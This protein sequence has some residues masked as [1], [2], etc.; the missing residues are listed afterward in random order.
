MEY[1]LIS[2]EHL[3][4]SLLF[5]DFDDFVVG[6]NYVAVQAYKARINMLAF[7]L[8][9]NHVHFVAEGDRIQVETFINGFKGE[10][11]RYLWNKYSI[12]ELLRRKS[13]DIRPIPK[14][15]ES[16][17]RAIAYVQMNCV[18]ANICAHPVEYPWG[19]G[20]TFFSAS[21]ENG[22]CLRDLSARERIRLLHT[23][24]ELPQ[25]WSVCSDGYVTP[26]SYVCKDFVERIFRTPKRMNFFL[27]NSSKAKQRVETGEKNMPAFRDQVIAAALP[28]LCRTLFQKP[29]VGELNEDQLVELLR[30]L[31]FRFSSNVNQLA[32]ITG[33]SYE[34][35]AEYLDRE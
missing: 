34:K 30:Q 18:A 4:D 21:C 1:W 31:R 11:S 24:L 20:N 7:I 25:Y 6:M 5:K 3:E 23:K 26:G 12:R 9:S 13:V 14:D 27:Q 10:Y 29:A 28:D 17:E 35:A 8:M 16:L 15:N 22:K 32:R 33:L 2:T 19:T